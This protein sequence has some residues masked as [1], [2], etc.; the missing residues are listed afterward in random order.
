[1]A[2]GLAFSGPAVGAGLTQSGTVP[3]EKGSAH[4]VAA[5]R[6]VVEKPRCPLE[7]TGWPQC[8]AAGLS[9]HV[10]EKLRLCIHCVWKEGYVL[11]Q[12][13]QQSC[14]PGKDPLRRT[15]PGAAGSLVG[16]PRT[17]V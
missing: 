12:Q 14:S 7:V 15:F 10:Y 9:F 2:V 17:H 13:C 1:M 5:S 8:S 3:G 4:P 6:E 11:L 16:E